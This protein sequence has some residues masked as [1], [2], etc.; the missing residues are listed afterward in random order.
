M[1]EEKILQYGLKNWKICGLVLIHKFGLCKFLHR[2]KFDNLNSWQ[3]YCPII[4]RITMEI[5]PIH[6]K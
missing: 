6:K 2:K 5:Y 1:E 3:S 4:D